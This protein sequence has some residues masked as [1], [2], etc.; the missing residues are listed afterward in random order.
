MTLLPNGSI[1]VNVKEEFASSP[2]AYSARANAE[3]QVVHLR[4]PRGYLNLRLEPAD[5]FGQERTAGL[6]PPTGAGDDTL[7]ID[8]VQPGRYWV[9]A[10]TSRGFV[11]SITSGTTDL[12]HQLFVVG[13]GGSSPPIE[14]TMRDGAAE[15]DGTIEGIAAPVSGTN[16][17][18][19]HVYCIPLADSGGEFKEVWVPAEGKFGPLQL[20]PGTYRVLAFD[21][22]Q[23]ELEYRSPEAMSAYDTKGQ[24]VHLVSGQKEHLH[25]QLISTSE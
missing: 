21:R 14:I 20:P 8:G 2:D 9:R 24:L 12:Q 4:G 22:P 25:L 18:S 10:D 19:V 17:E 3:G 5:D 6:R 1:S 7:T 16:A 13:L 23:P 11:A 15:I